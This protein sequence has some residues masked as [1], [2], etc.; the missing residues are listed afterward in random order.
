MPPE[1]TLLMS[2]GPTPTP[3]LLTTTPGT[4]PIWGMPQMQPELSARPSPS[5]SL[6]A[7][8][9]A[10]AEAWVPLTH[11]HRSLSHH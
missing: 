9:A 7:P 10:L 11:P 4:L 1:G 3:L 2:S 6:P 8:G 5:C